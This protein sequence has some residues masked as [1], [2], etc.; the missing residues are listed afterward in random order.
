[1]I[2]TLGCSAVLSGR[3]VNEIGPL[4][5][6]YGRLMKTIDVYNDLRKENVRGEDVKIICSGHKGSAEDM[7]RF[8]IE[9]GID[10]DKI[11][12]ESLARNTIENCILSYKIINEACKEKILD[13]YLVT[14]DYHMERAKIIFHFFGYLLN[15]EHKNLIPCPSFMLQYIQDPSPVQLEE[16]KRCYEKDKLIIKEKL[17]QSLEFYSKKNFQ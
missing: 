11:I 9:R 5:H 15:F 4:S 16:I 17:I 6:S 13:L 14:D 12:C 2:V 1:M 8:L 7:K 10:K 3:N